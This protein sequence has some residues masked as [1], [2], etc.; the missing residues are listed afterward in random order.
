MF[1][2]ALQNQE[3]E[4]FLNLIINL[5]N[6]DGDFSDEE[7]NQLS[8]YVS[9]LNIELK[10]LENYC[11]PSSELVASLQDSSDISK[12]VIFME[13]YALALADGLNDEEKELL[14]SIQEAFGFSD[15]FASEVSDW[16]SKLLPMY[17]KGYEL[18]GLV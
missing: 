1:L 16:Y 5:A 17:K 3:K 11:T 15:S 10:E 14:D 7:K 13:L 4:T 9:E 12:K 6:V 18:A 2:S 8:A